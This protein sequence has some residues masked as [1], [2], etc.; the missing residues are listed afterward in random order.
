M[1]GILTVFGAVC[2]L[3]GG[4]TLFRALFMSKRFYAKRPATFVMGWGLLA[5]SAAMFYFGG[6][7]GA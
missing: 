6:Q 2:A 3:V 4:L 1:G 5:L 7:S